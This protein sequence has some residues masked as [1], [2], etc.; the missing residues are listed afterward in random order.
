[1]AAGRCSGVTR[2]RK[3]VKASKPHRKLCYCVMYDARFAISHRKPPIQ[4]LKAG[5]RVE[6][7]HTHRRIPTQWC[8]PANR[9]FLNRR[10]PGRAN[11]V[12]SGVQRSAGWT[13]QWQFRFPCAHPAPLCTTTHARPFPAKCKCNTVRDGI[14]NPSTHINQVRPAF[15][16]RPGIESTR[17]AC[18]A[19]ESLSF[20]RDAKD[21]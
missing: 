10:P 21:D 9:F 4:S 3:P 17:R 15:F 18:T 1:M 16:S 8:V 11:W 20:G 5:E 7:T 12:L 14:F 2:K 6:C 13:T 19:A